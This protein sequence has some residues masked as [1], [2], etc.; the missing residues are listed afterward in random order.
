MNNELSSQKPEEQDLQIL[1]NLSHLERISEWQASGSQSAS[2]C[3][4]PL[5]F[6]TFQ[7][8]F[9]CE[10]IPDSV[11]AVSASHP[12]VDKRTMMGIHTNPPPPQTDWTTRVHSSVSKHPCGS[13]WDLGTILKQ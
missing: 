8:S 9:L 12:P 6:K 13:L 10:V 4:I 1:F 3:D 11:L 5:I 2:F 7:E